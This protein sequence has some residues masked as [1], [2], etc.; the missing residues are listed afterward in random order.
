MTLGQLFVNGEKVSAEDYIPP[1]GALS[2]DHQAVIGSALDWTIIADYGGDS[3]K[4]TA[5]LK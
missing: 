5:R 3:R 4:F 2:I 1:F